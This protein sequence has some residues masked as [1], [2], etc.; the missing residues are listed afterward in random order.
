MKKL[1]FIQMEK[2]QGGF[3]SVSE[4]C[5]AYAFGMAATEGLTPG[6]DLWYIYT[7]VTYNAC[8]SQYY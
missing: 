8:M 4:S 6:S 5:E 7:D 2:L 1:N 3:P